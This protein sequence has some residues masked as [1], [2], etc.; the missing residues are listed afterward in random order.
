[1]IL[2]FLLCSALL[3]HIP[4]HRCLQGTPHHLVTRSFWWVYYHILLWIKVLFPCQRLIKQTFTA[5]SDSSFPLRPIWALSYFLLIKYDRHCFC[6]VVHLLGL[7]ISAIIFVIILFN[8]NINLLSFLILCKS[9][10]AGLTSTG[11]GRKMC[12]ETM[13]VTSHVF[14]RLSSVLTK[15]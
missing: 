10:L 9:F 14:Q 11:W 5:L 4:N 6:L 7:P 3:N 13:E 8:V 2:I 12:K 1:M 15:A